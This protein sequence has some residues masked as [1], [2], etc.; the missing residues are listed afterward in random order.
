M[1]N[2][3]FFDAEKNGKTLHL[4]K[5][6]SKPSQSGKVRKKVE[7]LG[8]F[9]QYSESKKKPQP[10][11]NVAAPNQIPSQNSGAPSILQMM[12]PVPKENVQAPKGK[13][14]KMSNK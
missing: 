9:Q 14:A 5:S 12:A 2:H 10:A 3:P 4:L 7:L 11:A 1:P 8:S 6:A 13:D